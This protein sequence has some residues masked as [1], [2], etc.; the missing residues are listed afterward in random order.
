LGQ[1]WLAEYYLTEE[2]LS[3]MVSNM[4]AFRAM[5]HQMVPE[6]TTIYQE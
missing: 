3:R 2:V 5:T 4:N 6:N 1:V